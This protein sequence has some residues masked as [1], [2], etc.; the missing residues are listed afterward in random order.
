M[1][2][3][4]VEL[5][6]FLV[7]SLPSGATCRVLAAHYMTSFRSNKFGVHAMRLRSLVGAVTFL[8]LVFVSAPAFCQ[9][10]CAGGS[11]MAPMPGEIYF[12]GGEGLPPA[13]DAEALLDE[14]DNPAEV[15]HLTVVVPEAA[16][17][18]INGEETFTKG[19]SRTYVARGLKAGKVYT[20]AVE[21]LVE[22][23]T[24]AEFYKKED[25]KIKAGESNQVVLHLRRRVRTPKPMVPPLAPPAAPAPESL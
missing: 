22:H 11:M 8:S 16:K 18:S 17:V 6:S 7:D 24:G 2:V 9:C 19:I 4:K 10:N 13:M 25:V 3:L 14:V 5:P 23:P 21:G 20:F 15:A 1:I 12:D